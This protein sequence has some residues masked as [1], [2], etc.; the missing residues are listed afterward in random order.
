MC[1]CAEE[2]TDGALDT[3]STF[4]GIL[5]LVF[6]TSSIAKVS[7][8]IDVSVIW[9]D[10]RNIEFCFPGKIHFSSFS[11]K[12][13]WLIQCPTFT[14]TLAPTL[15]RAL[16]RNS[17]RKSL[18]VKVC[19]SKKLL[20]NAH[21]SNICLMFWTGALNRGLIHTLNPYSWLWTSQFPQPTCSFW[22]RRRICLALNGGPPILN[23]KNRL[24]TKCSPI[25]TTV[26]LQGSCSSPPCCQCNGVGVWPR[27]RLAREVATVEFVLDLGGPPSQSP[28]D[29]CQLDNSGPDSPEHYVHLDD[30]VRDSRLE[31][32]R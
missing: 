24:I 22:V 21:F 10:L 7:A 31:S 26:R 29:R 30:Q 28:R 11:R 17:S 32:W 8:E 20:D 2:V 16:K 18:E 27:S 3:F 14:L 4:L 1:K 15:S 5:S 25:Y 9:S 6:L 19:V 13:N 23:C 12:V